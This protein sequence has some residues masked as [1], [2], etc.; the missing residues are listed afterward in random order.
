MSKFFTLILIRQIPYNNS[1]DT[2]PLSLLLIIKRKDSTTGGRLWLIILTLYEVNLPSNFMQFDIW[3][4]FDNFKMIFLLNL[5]CL[6]DVYQDTKD[7]TFR[8]VGWDF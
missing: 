4:A 7:F 3:K 8:F 2:S 6:V 5:L 1:N